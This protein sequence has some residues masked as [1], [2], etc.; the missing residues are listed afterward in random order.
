MALPASAENPSTVEDVSLS[1]ATPS[2]FRSKAIDR[3]TL[4]NHDISR[5]Y[6]MRP[7]IFF[8]VAI[9][10]VNGCRTV[11]TQVDLSPSHYTVNALMLVVSRDATPLLGTVPQSELESIVKRRDTQT[12]RLPSLHIL[13]G[14]TRQVETGKTH[15]YPV[16]FDAEGNPTQHETARDGLTMRAT[17]SLTPDQRPKLAIAIEDS[18]IAKW[19]TGQSGNRLP[20]CELRQSSTTL[21]AEWGAWHNICTAMAAENNRGH[22]ILVRIDRPTKASSVR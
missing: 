9:L 12:T 20:V 21:L 2:T 16:G 5:E 14:E 22:V 17:L 13:P 19:M 15:V 11:S 6:R 4:N 1:N 7:H 3:V 8:C 18:H 10:S